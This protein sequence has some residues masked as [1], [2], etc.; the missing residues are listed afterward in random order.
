MLFRSEMIDDGDPGGRF[1][2]IVLRPEATISAGDADLALKLHHQAHAKC[3]IA[4]S[5]NCP[6][7]I[8]PRVTA[9]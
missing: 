1:T 9:A 7:E 2:R 6:V 5:L 3:F 4:N 8:E